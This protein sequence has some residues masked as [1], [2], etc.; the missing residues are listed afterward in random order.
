M[1]RLAGFKADDVI[2]KLQ[3]AGFVLVMLIRD[4][5]SIEKILGGRGSPDASFQFIDQRC[6]RFILGSLLV[7]NY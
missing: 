6:V 7:Y 2:R 3:R 4:T 1:G 5:E